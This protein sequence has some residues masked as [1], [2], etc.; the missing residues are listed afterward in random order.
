VQ[1]K[2]ISIIIPAFQAEKTILPA[3]NSLNLVLCE[4]PQTFEIIVVVDGI[5][6][7]TTELIKSEYGNTVKILE[8]SLNSG[9]GSAL[10][11]GIQESIGSS[12]VGFIDADLDISPRAIIRAWELL[13]AS[14]NLSLI[15]GSKLHRD[16]EVSYPII[17]K[18]QSILFAKFINLLFRFGVDDTQTGLKFG[19]ADLVKQA[20]KSTQM[21]GFAFD[22]EFLM[23]AKQMGATFATTPVQLNYQFESTISLFK[24]IQTLGEVIKILILALRKK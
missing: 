12:Y 8:L 11:L 6:D 19:R 15:V 2:D 23:R 1:K 22:L 3:L 13:Q 9:K 10:R 24:Y 16:S 14:E 7:N 21:N 20:A 4:I 17:R 18:S 5:V